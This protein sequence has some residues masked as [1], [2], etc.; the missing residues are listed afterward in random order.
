MERGEEE[1][2]KGVWYAGAIGGVHDFMEW[3]KLGGG[4]GEEVGGGT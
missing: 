3:G 1:G 4:E 2:K